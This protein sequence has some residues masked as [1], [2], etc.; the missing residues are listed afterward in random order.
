M[1]LRQL[2]PQNVAVLGERRDRFAG[3]HDRAFGDRDPQH[4]ACARREHR[5][6]AHLLGDDVAVGA[7]RRE[8]ALGD[9]E[10][11]LGGVDLDLRAHPATLE[12]D[13][14]VEVGLGLVALRLQRLDARVEPLHLKHELGVGDDGDLRP[15]RGAI[16][17]LHVEGGDRA[18]NARPRDQLMDR[19]DGGDHRF[20]VGDFSRVDSELFAGERG[21]RRHK[22]G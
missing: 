6:L 4:A 15:G 21:R 7:H 18:A 22:Q 20:L 10:G 11:G 12:L 9:V 17:F 13:C 16:A 2:Q 1:P 14:A 8:R 19:L 3:Q 5:A